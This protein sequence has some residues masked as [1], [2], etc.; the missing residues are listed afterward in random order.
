MGLTTA[1]APIKKAVDAK[2]RLIVA[3]DLPTLNEARS[4][5]ES[6][7]GLVST[8]KV[9]LTLQLA[10]GVE[11]FITELI[12]KGKKVFLDYKYFDIPETIQTAVKRAAD[13]GVTFLTVHGN[14]EIIQAAVRGRGTS[15][16]RILS[17]TVL[18]SLDA[19]DIK[20]LGF[21]CSV[22][23]LVLHRAKNALREGCDGVIASGQEAEAIR[24][25]AGERLL[26]VTPGIRP[27]GASIDDHKRPTTPSD[28]MRAGADYLVVGRPIYDPPGGEAPRIAATKILAAMQEAFDAAA[29]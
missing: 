29:R 12:G 18:T 22:K 28:A 7:D 14:R 15:S 6:L 1:S 16:L 20:D 26:I 25:F 27:H 8:F 5:V 11:S 24:E 13:L 23:E 10:I 2:E 19:S 17:V 4:M 21:D 9:G 3:L